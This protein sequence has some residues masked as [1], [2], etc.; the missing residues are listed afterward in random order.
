M[1][2]LLSSGIIKAQG[3]Y[4]IYRELTYPDTTAFLDKTDLPFSVNPEN[5][6]SIG[7]GKTQ[8]ANGK[9]FNAMMYNPA[10]L[11]RKKNTFDVLNLSASM[12]ATTFEA[13]N[14]VRNN[15]AQLRDGYFLQQVYDSY[16]DFRVAQTYDDYNNALKKLKDALDF[17]TRLSDQVIGDYNDPDVHG[18]RIIPTISGQFGNFGFSVH[19]TGQAGFIGLP[20][21]A[22]IQLRNLQIPNDASEITTEFLLNLAAIAAEIIDNSN[23]IS[24]SVLPQ[25]FAMSYADI[26]AAVGYGFEVT[27]NFQV[28]ANLKVINRRL[29][30]KFITADNYEHILVEAGKELKKNVTGFTIDLG[31]LYKF[32]KTETE[33]GL[34]I[35][36]LIPVTKITSNVNIP[37]NLIGY[38]YARD[39]N[40]NQILVGHVDQNGNYTPDPAGDTLLYQISQMVDIISPFELQAPLLINTGATHPITKD[41]DVSLEWVDMI[42]QDEK[43]TDYFERFRIGTEYRLF[44][45]YLSVRAGLAD[46]RPTV[47]FGVNLRVF[48]LDAAYAYD[49]FVEDYSFFAQIRFGW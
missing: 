12:P 29:S 6:K 37:A 46:K 34:S 28:G 40:T 30:T 17:P 3:G 9:Y 11:S 16:N 23:N 31:A 36:N 1:I 44:E 13:A 15:Q 25:M 43:Y 26:V 7:M 41:W 49:N 39:Q 14:F 22:M 27:K 45:N 10:L 5:V 18:V 42:A 19:G 32:E 8:I 48:H 33:I 2:I 21:E 38:D 35:Q 24:T 4:V 20:T 47:G